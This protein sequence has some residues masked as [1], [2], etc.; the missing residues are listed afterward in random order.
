[1]DENSQ[2]ATPRPSDGFDGAKWLRDG[3]WFVA[4][5]YGQSGIYIWDSSGLDTRYL[6]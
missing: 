1:M 6:S 4:T 2:M 5:G 3:H